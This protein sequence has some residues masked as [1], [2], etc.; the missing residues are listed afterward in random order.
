MRFF[1]SD[2]HVGHTKVILYCNRPYKDVAE[3][4]EAIIT[5]MNNT[6][7]E[8]DEFYIL[9]DLSLNPKWMEFIMSRII[10]KNVYLII[11]NHD[12]C[13]ERK[14]GAKPEKTAKMRERYFKAGFKRLEKTMWLTLRNK[15]TGKEYEV[16]LSHFPFIPKDVEKED[17]RYL[18]HRPEDKGQILLAGHSH[19][20]YRKRDKMIDVGYDGDLRIFSEDDIVALIEDPRDFIETPI[21]EHYKQ[22]KLKED[23]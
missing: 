11:G 22:R 14:L 9:G 15:D 20:W 23:V 2:F 1:G 10:C 21:S 6:I 4:N 8:D 7:K 13:F 3:M 19:C 17:T 18:N 5:V 12:S 16:Q